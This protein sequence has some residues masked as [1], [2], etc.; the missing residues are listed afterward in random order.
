MFP[1][2]QRVVLVCRRRCAS[3]LRPV[4]VPFAPRDFEMFPF[5]NAL[6]SFIGV[7]ENF[8]ISQRVVLVYAFLKCLFFQRVV[9]SGFC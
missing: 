5:V 7:F 2:F 9:E 1:F 6:F 3:R 4:C 8:P